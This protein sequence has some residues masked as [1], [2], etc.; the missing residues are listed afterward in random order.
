[1]LL[2]RILALCF[3]TPNYN[4]ILDDHKK[5]II[6]PITAG[7]WL[8]MLYFV[9]FCANNSTTL[10]KA[11]KEVS[12]D[13]NYLFFYRNYNLLTTVNLMKCKT[14]K[15]IFHLIFCFMLILSLQRCIRQLLISF[16]GFNQNISITSNYWN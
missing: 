4:F 5:L 2:K 7:K 8:E 9:L 1:M 3:Y 14:G 6:L 12:R 15:F 10:L 16:L 11:N 13:F